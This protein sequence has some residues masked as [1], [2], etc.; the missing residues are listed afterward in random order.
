V[1]FGAAQP[2]DDEPVVIVAEGDDGL[3]ALTDDDGEPQIHGSRDPDVQGLVEAATRT[4]GPSARAM[5][6]DEF[7]KLAGG[8]A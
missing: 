4:Y 3:M 7:K 2:S 8:A 5:P 1:Q 6:F